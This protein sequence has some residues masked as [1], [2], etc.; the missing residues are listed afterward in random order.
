MTDT[1]RRAAA[2]QFAADWQ[3]KGY[4]KGH[5]QTF[6]LSLLQKVYGV[7]EP[8]KFITFEDQIMLDH[9]SFIDG[10]IPSTHVLIEQ[11]SL[12]KELNKPIKQSD[13]SLL[14]PFQQAKRYAA[15]LPYSQRP[16]WIVTC[17]F[18][19][20]YVYDMERPTGDP[21]IIKLCDLE[22]EYYR[23]QFLVDTGDTNIKKEMEVSLQAGEIVGVLYDALLKQYKAPEAVDTQKSLNALCVRLVFCLYA[24]DAG[25]F[26]NKS[27]FHD[28]L[29]DIPASGIRKALV[30]LFR[31]LDQ[32]PEQRDKY[33]ADDNPALAAFPYVNG[34]LFSDENIEIPPFTEELKNLLLEKASGD[35]DWSVI[36]PTIFGAVFESTLN[37][38]TRR[39]G[40]M[41]YTSIENIH[42]V[43]DPLFLDGLRSELEEIKEIAV[44]K[45]R[46][47]RLDTFQSKLAGLTF[48]D[49]ACGS[50]NFLT[51]TYLSLRK[52]EN[53]VLRCATDQISMDLDGIIQVSIGQFYGIEINDFAVTVAKTALWIA[54]SQMMKETEDVVHMSLDFLP[55]KSYA[56]ITE[57]NA[58]RLDWESVVPKDKLNYIMGNPPFVG[59][60]LQSKGQKEDILSVYVD[61]KGKPYKTAGKIDYVSGWYFKAAQL[62]QETDIRTAFVSTNSITQG[63]QV[64]GVW[65]P[66]YDRFG[67]HIDFAHRT[68]RWDSEA[69]IKAHVHC[70][71]VGF[72]PAPNQA[73]KRIYTMERY[74][75][76]ENINPYLLDA[77]N[78]F[79]DSRNK[80]ICDV[81]LMTT[82]NRPADGGHL[83]IEADEYDEFIAKEPNAL[84][85]IKRLVGAAEF[86]NNKKRWCLWLVGISPAELRKMPL[87]LQRVEACKAD[88][89]NAPDAGRRKLAERPTQFREINNPDTSVVVPAVSSERRRYVPIGFLDKNTIATNLVI[90]IPDAQLYHF[91]VLTSNVHMAW[92]RAVCGRLKS[93][94]RY[95]KDVVYN[96]FPWPTLTDAQKAK[97]EQTA[98]AI[99]DARALYPDC[100]LADLYDEIAM[101]PELRKAHQQN[102][103]AVMQAY[104]FDVATTTETSCVAE[105]MRMYQKLTDREG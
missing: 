60:S 38:E 80:P 59:Y 77:P 104:G 10:F 5:S 47:A 54:E 102:D 57:G 84:S 32:K 98:Q 73:P 101:P 95:S 99:L 27:M 53:E 91:G 93:D 29:R 96:N 37:P 43:I 75:E 21:E 78:A 86:I 48:L 62:M 33:L 58:L 20:F 40:G 85:Y 52:L 71:I 31:I 90:T 34:G 35:F 17:N 79:V 30:E 87:V 66:L 22:K 88:R 14:S 39:S 82:G 74:Q 72:S 2:K 13:G 61:E 26:G 11:K 1:Q 83:I 97:I 45:T 18:A 41:H 15:E 44:D 42:K 89:E 23:L 92:M 19:E 46:K 28:Y 3:G 69:S 56:N 9:T 25:I 16:R 55:L 36:S 7:E 65:K 68:F 100:S 49:P 12:G 67:I 6:W 81:P 51:E 76:A 24:E 4:E 50:G 105:L 70:V 8:D 103:R 94:Y 64:A 63:E